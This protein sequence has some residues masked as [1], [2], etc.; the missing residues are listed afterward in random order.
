M[1]GLLDFHKRGLGYPMFFLGQWLIFFA[2]EAFRTATPIRDFTK[3]SNY[4]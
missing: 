3:Q 4:E 1:S 2:E